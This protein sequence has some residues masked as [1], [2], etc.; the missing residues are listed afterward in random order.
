MYRAARELDGP[1]R[2]GRHWSRFAWPAA[3]VL[4]MGLIT[5]FL[6]QDAAVQRP[7]GDGAGSAPG[8][9]QGR[10]SGA[11]PVRT[12]GRYAVPDRKETGGSGKPDAGMPAFSGSGGVHRPRS[13]GKRRKP[14]PGGGEGP[15]RTDGAPAVKFGG[16]WYYAKPAKL[17]DPDGMCPPVYIEM[18][19]S[20]SM[21]KVAGKYSAR[22]VVGE[23]SISP[24]VE[25]QFAGA[26]REP[27]ADLEWSGPGGAAGRVQLTLLSARSVRVEWSADRV[28][29]EMGFAAGRATLVR[30]GSP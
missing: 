8:A 14:V 11:W 6:A 21:G 19:I 13:S 9:Q 17:A 1:F 30:R 25:F 15:G 5:L 18:E 7:T 26:V 22:Y 27:A 20:Q 24:F 10:E 3:G 23:R 28:G 2:D 16:E 4:G 12:E 29:M